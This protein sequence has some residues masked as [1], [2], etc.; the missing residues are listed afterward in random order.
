MFTPVHGV[1]VKTLTKIDDLRIKNRFAN[2]KFI[3]KF[4]VNVMHEITAPIRITAG[5]LGKNQPERDLLVS[6]NHSMLV[7]D[8][9]IFAKF[10]VNDS[11]I[12]QDMSFEKIEYFHVLSDNH[13]VINANGAMSETLG[14]EEIAIFES[15]YSFPEYIETP[16]NSTLKH[17]TTRHDVDLINFNSY[18]FT[19]M[20]F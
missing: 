12:Y 10:L 7:G 19:E 16:T 3:G 5:A 8:R 15:L 14:S 17:K 6:P 13:Y 1:P 20:A 18:T 9:L 2:I 11:T 4:T